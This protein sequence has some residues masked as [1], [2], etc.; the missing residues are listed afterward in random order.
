MRRKSILIFF[1]YY[2]FIYFVKGSAKQIAASCA[3]SAKKCERRALKTFRR[4]VKLLRKLV[5]CRRRFS[6]DKNRRARCVRRAATSRRICFVR[7]FASDVAEL[8]KRA[9]EDRR[10]NR[11]ERAARACKNVDCFKRRDKRT[12][13]LGR[14][15]R[16]ARKA[17]RQARPRCGR[18]SRRVSKCADDNCRRTQQ[19]G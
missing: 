19:R 10:L 13:E 16:A 2:L 18:C 14:Q 1:H 5:S 15:I 11:R 6:D 17:R 8:R 3:R 7:R 9:R 4:I 12:A